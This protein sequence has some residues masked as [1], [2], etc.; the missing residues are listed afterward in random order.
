[1]N[2]VS[3]SVARVLTLRAAFSQLSKAKNQAPSR[4]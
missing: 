4:R 1:M 3:R 2:K